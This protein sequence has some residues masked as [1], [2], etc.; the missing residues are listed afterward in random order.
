[1]CSGIFESRPW[2]FWL[3]LVSCL[4]WKMEMWYPGADAED[5]GGVPCVS[6]EMA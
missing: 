3:S 2:Q 4:A 5:G 1:M 6:P